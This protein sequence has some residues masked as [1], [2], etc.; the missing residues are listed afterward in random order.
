MFSEPTKMKAGNN[1]EMLA[2]ISTFFYFIF[3]LNE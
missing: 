2:N 3:R 1:P